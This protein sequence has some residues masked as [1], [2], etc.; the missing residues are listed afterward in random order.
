MDPRQNSEEKAKV[1]TDAFTKG[2]SVGS[3]ISNLFVVAFMAALSEE[4]F[5]RGILQKVLIECTKNKHVG[6]WIG[7]AL[8]SA[9]HMQFFGFLPRMLMGA[10]LGYLFLWSG[11]L[12]PGIIAHFCNN[13]MAVFLSWMMNRESIAAD[14]DQIGSKDGEIMYA[15][16]STLM[17]I[18]SLFLVYKIEKKRNN[19]IVPLA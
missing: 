13:G 8:F 16:I 6:V 3:L 10:F 18:G 11:S 5:F 19:V 9:F 7:A 14:A 15:A 1:L 12:W 2:T 17:V 4:L